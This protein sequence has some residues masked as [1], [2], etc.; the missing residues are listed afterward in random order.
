[1]KMQK[2]S[3]VAL[4]LAAVFSA[5]ATDVSIEGQYLLF[6]VVQVSV[7]TTCRLKFYRTEDASGPLYETNNVRFATDVNGCFV[8]HVTAP[9]SVG[10][11]DTFWVGVTPAG[12]GELSPR[13]RV[14]PVPFA[15]AADEAQLVSLDNE[16]A[17]AGVATIDRL[18]VS[19]DVE[20]EVFVVATNSVV[21]T[22]NLRLDSAKVMS[23]AV[24]DG[25]LLGLFNAKGATPSFDY[26]TFSAEKQA[27]VEAR[28]TTSGMF[29]FY[30]NSYTQDASADWTFDRDGF[31]TIA[32]KADPKKCPAPKLTVAVGAAKILDNRT[33]GTDRGSAVKRFMTV[34]YRA[35]EHVSVKVTAVGAGEHANDWWG[36]EKSDYKASIG[37]KARLMRFGRD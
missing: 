18:D 1:M 26:D 21:K 14:A 20:A 32:V 5:S 7:D 30:I 35:G 23:L 33:I 10:L 4:T 9:D 22:R 16:L 29:D 19:G 24:P 31:L 34:P 28:V 12:R 13:F 15:F 3:L 8:I 2:I 6:D 27:S 25:G 17:L 11:P 37:V 36:G